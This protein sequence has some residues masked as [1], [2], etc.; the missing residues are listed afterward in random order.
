MNS[1]DKKINDLFEVVRQK[2]ADV[3]AAEKE[4]KKKWETN[5]S[6]TLPISPNTPPINIQTANE[7]TVKLVVVELLKHREYVN[8]AESML[9]LSTSE[10]YGSYEYG[11][12][13]DDCKKRVA[14]ISLL[15][16]K[17]SLL[18]LEKRLNGIVSPEQK[19]AMELAEIEKTLKGQ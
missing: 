9:G 8:K 11:Q 14:S 6:I 7:A 4:V 13:F 17:E 5:C 15:S 19:R 16:K 1:I 10:K 12:W 2:R 18:E 3:E